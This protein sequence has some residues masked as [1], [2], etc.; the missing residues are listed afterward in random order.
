MGLPNSSNP[1][2]SKFH[3]E[4]SLHTEELQPINKSGQN[5]KKIMRMTTKMPQASLP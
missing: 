3:T 5:V 2:N 1:N 4:P